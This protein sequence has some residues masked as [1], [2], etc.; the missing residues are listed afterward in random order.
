MAKDKITREEMYPL[1]LKAVSKMREEAK[2][3]TNKKK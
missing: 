1:F 3:E 2:K